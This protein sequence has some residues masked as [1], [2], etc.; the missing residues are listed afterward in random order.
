MARPFNLPRVARDIEAGALLERF[1][2]AAVVTVLVIRGYLQAM[3][4]P[5]IGGHGLHIAHMLW[6]GLLMVVAIA[7]LLA[8]LG[9]WIQR[10]AALVGGIGFGLFI[11]ELGKFITSDNNY[12]YEPTFALMYVIFVLLFLAFRVIERQQRMSDNEYLVNAIALL[13]EAVLDRVHPEQKDRALLLIQRSAGNDPFTRAVRQA[14]RQVAAA[15]PPPPNPAQRLAVWVRDR[16]EALIRWQWFHRVLLLVACTDATLTLLTGVAMAFG[17]QTMRAAFVPTFWEWGSLLTSTAS[18]LLTV[19]GVVRLLRAGRL[20][21]YVWFRR[22]L[23]VSIFLVQFF[24]FYTDQL[25]AVIGVALDLIFLAAVDYLLNSERARQ[26]TA[27]AGTLETAAP[28][29]AARAS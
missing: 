14:L 7:L 20:A 29:P 12:F 16:Y 3:N 10:V 19:V 27:L 8:F 28:E 25:A 23:L 6:G 5:Q 9:N 11:D 22:A 2:V 21:G 13:Q 15:P 26:A 4:Y 18:A 17:G 24:A 1:L